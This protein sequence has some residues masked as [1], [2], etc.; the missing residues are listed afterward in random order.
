VTPVLV[1]LNAGLTH[2]DT[3]LLPITAWI[4]QLDTH[5]GRKDLHHPPIGTFIF[6]SNNINSL[7]GRKFIIHR[8]WFGKRKGEDEGKN[9]A[10]FVLVVVL[11]KVPG[12]LCTLSYFRG[13]RFMIIASSDNIFSSTSVYCYYTFWTIIENKPTKEQHEPART[14]NLNFTQA[15]KRQWHFDTYTI[16]TSNAG[17]SSC[18]G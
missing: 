13:S 1:Q 9:E 16:R 7:A 11:P 5:A 2:Q 15:N 3:I 17:T 12:R 10:C 6:A 8:C 18:D 4:A 14:S